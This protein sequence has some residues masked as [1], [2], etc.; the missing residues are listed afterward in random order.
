VAFWII[1]NSH[2]FEDA[3]RKAV[4]LGADADTLGA[5][6]GSIAEVIW[7]IPKW[8]KERAMS[9]LPEAMQQVVKEFR[10]QIHGK[11]P[12]A[13]KEVKEK[14]E[15]FIKMYWKQASGTYYR[16]TAD[17]KLVE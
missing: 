12:D 15:I 11:C 17:S 6:V 7:G 10:K 3:I 14:S 13:E 2:S 8:M 9:Y 5:I 1:S 16:K 4:S